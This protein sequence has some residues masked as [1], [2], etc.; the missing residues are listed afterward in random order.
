MA[1]KAGRVCRIQ[2]ECAVSEHALADRVLASRCVTVADALIYSATIDQVA[3]GM[4][5]TGD[6]VVV[7]SP[8]GRTASCGTA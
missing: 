8:A 5:L 1:H 4:G 7:G 3:P 2:G 6:E